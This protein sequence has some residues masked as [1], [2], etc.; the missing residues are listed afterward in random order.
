MAEGGKQAIQAD[1]DVVA[2]GE[3][4]RPARNLLKTLSV[5]VKV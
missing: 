4:H 3:V 5:W 2:A 1:D